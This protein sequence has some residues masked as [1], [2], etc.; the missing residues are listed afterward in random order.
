ML[1]DVI[2][3]LGNAIEIW[4]A[5]DKPNI[6]ICLGLSS[7]MLTATKAN[8]HNQVF[9][10]KIVLRKGPPRRGGKVG[11]SDARKKTLNQMRL[12][13]MQLMP[14]PTSVKNPSNKVIFIGM[15]LCIH[16]MYVLDLK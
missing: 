9:W 13:R 2:K 12:L 15:G 7:Q 8:F 4:L 11:Y 14:L 3:E 5:P 16:A 1:L 6:C 10:F